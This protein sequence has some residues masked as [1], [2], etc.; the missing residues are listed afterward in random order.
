MF[1]VVIIFIIIISPP[2]RNPEC[3]W[4]K[5]EIKQWLKGRKTETIKLSVGS[6]KRTAVREKNF[7]IL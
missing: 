1:V 3:Y 5:T 7:F 4:A 6:I 2:C